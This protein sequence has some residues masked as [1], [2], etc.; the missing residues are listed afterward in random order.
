MPHSKQWKG[1]QSK[2]TQ[3]EGIIKK[4]MDLVNYT[5]KDVVESKC[6]KEKL[7]ENSLIH[8]CW[9]GKQSLLTTQQRSEEFQISP[10]T[11]RLAVQGLISAQQG[12]RTAHKA[13]QLE[14]TATVL[15][16]TVA[17]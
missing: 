16:C 4:Q 7:C 15:K 8:F 17:G 3:Q 6:F 2:K 10:E 11:L 14:L 13:V 12:A 5:E 1:S 9:F